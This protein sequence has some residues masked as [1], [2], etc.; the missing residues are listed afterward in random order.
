METGLELGLGKV[1]KRNEKNVF[2]VE[3]KKKL[4]K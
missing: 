3:K 2:M 4:L 1:S